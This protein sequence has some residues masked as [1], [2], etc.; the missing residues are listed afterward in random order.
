MRPLRSAL[1]TSYWYLFL[2]DRPEETIAA[3]QTHATGNTHA[4]EPRR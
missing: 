4:S 1:A 2:K 3:E